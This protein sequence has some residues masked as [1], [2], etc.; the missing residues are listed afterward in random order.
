MF[1]GCAEP[2]TELLSA[3]YPAPRG[4]L[5]RLHAEF[6]HSL[7]AKR[8]YEDLVGKLREQGITEDVVF[9]EITNVDYARCSIPSC[10]VQA[11]ASFGGCKP[12]KKG[13]VWLCQQHSPAITYV[14]E[15]T[16]EYRVLREMEHSGRRQDSDLVK[17][18]RAILAA[19]AK[20]EGDK[21]YIESICKALQNQRVGMPQRWLNDWA[22]KEFR[23]EQTNW[24]D[25]YQDRTAKSRIQKYISKS[26]TPK[27]RKTV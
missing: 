17:R 25:A 15:L 26:C 12:Y 7:V 4:P 9:S 3:S 14:H 24:F 21:N 2:P 22:K 1:A 18:Q 5:C 6:I 8:N 20:H 27:L 13:L 11:L 23:V 19:F 10:S 16:N